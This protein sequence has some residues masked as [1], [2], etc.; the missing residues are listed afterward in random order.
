MYKGI[1]NETAKDVMQKI[2][3]EEKQH[4]EY[5]KNLLML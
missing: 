4:V 5:F 2:I 3:E 1:T